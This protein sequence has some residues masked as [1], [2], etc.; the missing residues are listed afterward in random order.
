MV[1]INKLLDPYGHAIFVPRIAGQELLQRSRLHVRSECDRLDAF[2]GQLSQLPLDV[3]LQLS[4][5]LRASET[6]REL[7]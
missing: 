2:A 7:V 1:A 3:G 6:I 5:W 4:A